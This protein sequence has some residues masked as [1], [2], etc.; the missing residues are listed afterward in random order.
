MPLLPQG[1]SQG[2]MLIAIIAI[3]WTLAVVSVALRIWARHIKKVQF[4]IND[5]AIFVAIVS[6]WSECT[7][8]YTLALRA[9]LNVAR[10]LQLDLLQIL[11]QVCT[12]LVS[13]SLPAYLL[14]ITDCG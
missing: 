14:I 1:D 5:Y 8:S 11:S 13:R 9:S 7:S 4:V 3:F 10:Y 6:P 2:V 12:L